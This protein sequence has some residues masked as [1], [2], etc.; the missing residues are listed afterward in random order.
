MKL[1]LRYFII[2]FFEIFVETTFVI[3]Y[4][5]LVKNTLTSKNM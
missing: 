3:F 5:C 2:I 1:L 4:N